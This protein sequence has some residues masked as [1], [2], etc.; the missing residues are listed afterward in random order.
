MQRY[1]PKKIEKLRSLAKDPVLSTYA[2]MKYMIYLDKFLEE[3]DPS[4]NQQSKKE[5]QRKIIASYNAG[6][7]NMFNACFEINRLP[8]T[9]YPYKTDAT[10]LSDYVI[11]LMYK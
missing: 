7:G 8:N 3:N 4:Y 2:G 5:Q 9:P 10:Q 11:G 6:E 1:N